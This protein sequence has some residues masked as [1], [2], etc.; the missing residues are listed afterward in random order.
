MWKVIPAAMLG[1]VLGLAAC[2]SNF[3]RVENDPNIPPGWTATQ[4]ARSFSIPE[5]STGPMADILLNR[6]FDNGRE[7]SLGDR[8][9]KKLDHGVGKLL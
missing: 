9:Y 8:R 3:E 2:E 1:A 6:A 7:F 4:Q 5:D